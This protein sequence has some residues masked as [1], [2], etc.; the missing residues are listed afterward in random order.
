MWEHR[1]TQ[2]RAALAVSAGT[3][4]VS[5]TARPL[6]ALPSPRSLRAAAHTARPRLLPTRPAPL[7]V[8]VPVISALLLGV[9]LPRYLLGEVSSDLQL[10]HPPQADLP[11]VFIPAARGT[12]HA[13]QGTR[14]HSLTLVYC[15][16]SASSRCAVSKLR[17]VC[18]FC[19]GL[20][21]SHQ[22]QFLIHSRH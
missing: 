17:D 22:E 11:S 12:R 21:T 1:H 5:R 15:L 6:D 8:P 4:L 14:P 13:A 7:L 19:L 20:S 2:V 10:A 9:L 18:L 16:A 3:C